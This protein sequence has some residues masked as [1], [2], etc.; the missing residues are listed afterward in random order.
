LGFE[1]LE[2]EDQTPSVTLQTGAVRIWIFKAAAGP[3]VRRAPDP[4]ANPAGVDHLSLWVEDVDLAYQ[5]LGEA[6]VEF[7]SEPA[8][9]PWGARATS[10]VDPDGTRIFFLGPLRSV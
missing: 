4:S 8:D 3:P 2:R 6:G 1:V 5:S 10:V 7:E 9:Q